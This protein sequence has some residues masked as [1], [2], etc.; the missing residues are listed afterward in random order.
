M[1]ADHAFLAWKDAHC[2]AS[3]AEFQV[4]LGASRPASQKPRQEQ[5][6]EAIRLRKIASENLQAFLAASAR[7]PTS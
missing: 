3:E 6:E 1:N 2:K 7:V 5:I 4:Q